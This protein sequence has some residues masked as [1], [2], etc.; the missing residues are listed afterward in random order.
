M[1]YPMSTSPLDVRRLCS[2]THLHG[3]DI[4]VGDNKVINK[5]RSISVPVSPSKRKLPHKATTI[6]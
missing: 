5:L 6:T 4:K 1:M 3:N 2:E